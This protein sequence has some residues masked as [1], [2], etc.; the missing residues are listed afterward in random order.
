MG[1]QM[2]FGSLAGYTFPVNTFFL[3]RFDK[4]DY[5]VTFHLLYFSWVHLA[6]CV[7]KTHLVPFHY[8]LGHV[9]LVDISVIY[10]YQ[11]KNFE[12]IYCLFCTKDSSRQNSEQAAI[13]KLTF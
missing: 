3:I 1:K 7:S 10:F 8:S 12:Q 9:A 4:I 6:V 2:S 13:M 11:L 5:Y